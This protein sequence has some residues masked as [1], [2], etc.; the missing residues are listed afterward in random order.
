MVL[1]IERTSNRIGLVL[2]LSGNLDVGHLDELKAEVSKAEFR[3]ALDLEEVSLVDVET[4][5]FLGAC[6]DRGMILLH[7]PPY[8]R[9]WINREKSSDRNARA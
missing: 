8:I 6:E 9:E 2:R 5:Q 7:C 4:V 3:T 1:R